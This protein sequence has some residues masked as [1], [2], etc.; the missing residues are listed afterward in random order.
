VKLSGQVDAGITANPD[1]PRNGLNFGRL[2]DDR[3]NSP[4]LNQLLV[5][6]ERPLDTKLADQYQLGFKFQGMYG[7]DARYTHFLGELADVTRDRNQLDIVEA[8]ANLHLPLLTKDGIDVK[9]GQYVTLEGAEVIDAKGNFFYSHTYIFNFG[10]PFKHTGILT[11]THVNSIL[12]VYLGVDSGVNTSLGCGS[13]P[14]LSNGDNN[15]A[16]AFHGGFGLNLLNGDLTVSATTHIGP[17][18][19][20]N[21]SDLRYLSDI[22]AVWKATKKLTLTTDLNYI[23]DEGLKASGWGIAQYAAYAINDHWTVGVRGEIWRDADG[24]FV[25]AFPN[26]RDFVKAEEGL[27]N[28]SFTGGKTTYTALTLGANYKPTIEDKRFEGLVIR[29]ELRWDW[30]SS[31]SPFNS[32]HSDS[33]FTAGIDVVIPFTVPQPSLK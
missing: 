28:T 24:A 2:F 27:P 31:T 21:N 8:Y 29:P 3:A 10:I 15:C 14:S 5:T 13:R 9:V 4:L 17:E 32:L 23:T 19:P 12:D 25:A 30:S 26:S 33:Q 18:L 20:Q 6:A 7:S 16:A 1:G 22:T 11:T